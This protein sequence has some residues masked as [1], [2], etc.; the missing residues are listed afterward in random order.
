[1]LS[2]RLARFSAVVLPVL[3]ELLLAPAKVCKP[4]A[5]VGGVPDIS[6]GTGLAGS[7][8]ILDFSKVGKA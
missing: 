4:G 6:G 7:S 2:L 1:M 8:L 3:E 5:S